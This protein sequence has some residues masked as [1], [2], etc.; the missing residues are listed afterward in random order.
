MNSNPLS[1]PPP[2]LRI[3]PLEAVLPHELG[4]VQR[5]Q[6]LIAR[7]SA[8][9][10]FTNPPIVASIDRD[11]Y[12]LMDGSNRHSAFAALGFEQ[13]LA[14][15]AEY[16]SDQVALDVW[17]HIV[18]DWDADSLLQMLGE[19]DGIELA[20]GS[21]DGALARI[22]LR[23]GGVYSI[24]APARN[25]AMRNAA[26]RQLVDGYHARATLYRT[27]LTA[28]A[29]I[30]SLF[31]RG[32]AIVLFPRYEPG[33][34]IKAALQSAYLPPGI[35]RHIIHGRALN[36]SYPMAR[37][38]AKASLEAKNLELQAWLETQYAKRSVRYYA[39]STYHFDE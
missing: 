33:D 19:L 13:I 35:S 36:L 27:P 11:R 39:E 21:D 7:L 37:L 1:A 3:V 28:P 34:I 5:S 17:Q 30:W 20:E 24:H 15:I 29:Q 6:P 8:A 25:L 16:G 38:R 31:P 32:V 23:D 22:V 26:L 9:R 2:L 4:D 10:V 18:S 14:Q 12:V